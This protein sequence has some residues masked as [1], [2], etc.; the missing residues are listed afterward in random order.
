MTIIYIFLSVITLF[1]IMSFISLIKINKQNNQINV[2][3]ISDDRYYEL[4]Y[5]LQFISSVGVIVIAVAGFFG[6][7]K[8]ENFVEEF[9]SK[10]DSLD[11]KL[12][13]YDKKI[14]VLDSTISKYDNKINVYD[15]FLKKLDNSKVQFSRAMIA[16]N[17][18]LLQLKDTINV[19][20]KRNILDKSFYVIDNLQIDNH[21]KNGKHVEINKKF[22][23][24]DMT[25]IIGDQLPDFVNKPVVF[26]IPQSTA[27]IS[28]IEVTKDYV[29][30][31]YGMHQGNGAKEDPT[32]FAFGLLIA[33]KTE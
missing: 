7:D 18:G 33:R 17:K 15:N 11:V 27:D 14:T 29:V 26:V 6:L 31:D 32:S 3:G 28:L 16:S 25:T 19:I 21:I 5:K 1:V 23:F 12:I 24:K 10:T 8:Y 9:K 13:Q 22:Y 20:K 4:K 30:V 2:N